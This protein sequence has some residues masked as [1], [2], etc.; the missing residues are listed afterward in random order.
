MTL[1]AFMGAAIAEIAGCF[2]FWAWL[3][4]NKSII[5]IIPGILSLMLFAFLL[6]FVE[7]DF[8]GRAYATYGTIY[9]I[10]SILWMWGIEGNSPDLFDV[11]GS[12][13][14]IIGAAIIFLA[15]RSSLY[16]S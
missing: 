9:I 6:T 15:P 1:L 11:I 16:S 3:K 2:S 14:C 12:L 4:L 5:W 13:I 10:A 7:S 8:A